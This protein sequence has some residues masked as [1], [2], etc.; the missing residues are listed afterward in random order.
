MKFALYVTFLSLYSLISVI[1]LFFCYRKMDLA[2]RITKPL[3]FISLFLATLF[4]APQFPLIYVA[5]LLS[6]IGDI[7][8]IYRDNMIIF[9]LAGLSFIAEHILNMVSMINLL[10]FPFPWWG[11]LIVMIFPL[12]CALAGYFISKKNPLFFLTTGFFSFHFINIVFA[13]MLIYAHLFLYGTLIYAGY[14]F[15]ILSDYLIYHYTFIK[16]Q[17]NEHFFVMLTYI[18]AQTLILIPLMFADF[19]VLA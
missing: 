3:I 1:H 7:L 13:F 19:F 8:M 16:K 14:L 5:C 11:Y 15:Y 6:A 4:F 9:I 10:S 2:R 17:K 12:I 18:I